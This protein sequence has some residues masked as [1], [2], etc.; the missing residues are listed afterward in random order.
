MSLESSAS[1]WDGI[2]FWLIGV[3]AGLAFV[4]TV[5]AVHARKLG[6]ELATEKT[7]IAA[8]EKAASDRAIAEAN[9]R[10]AD[11]NKIAEQE[12]LARL[13]LEAR[14]APRSLSSEQSV[15]LIS[16]LKN[17]S[18]AEID[19]CEYPNDFETARLTSQ[20]VESLKAAAWTVN[21]FRP[22]APTTRIF[23]G[24]AVLI[25]ESTAVER[26]RR[27]AQTLADALRSQAL[28][29]SGPTPLLPTDVPGLAQGSPKYSLRLIVGSKP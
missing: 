5:A 7:A 28:V 17:F 18:G 2:S 15:D 11:A 13:Q 14:L 19:V 26:E 20:I 25:D 9:A 16:K 4:G 24:L 27:A 22:L 3:G 21:G 12:R 29:V 1:L 8:R 23:A 10:A 6:R